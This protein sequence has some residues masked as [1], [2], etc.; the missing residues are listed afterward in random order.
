MNCFLLLIKRSNGCGTLNSYLKEELC[1]VRFD[2]ADWYSTTRLLPF[3]D[4]RLF[5]LSHLV[6]LGIAQI[7]SAKV[8]NAFLLVVRVTSHFFF[9]LLPKSRFLLASLLKASLY[10]ISA[11]LTYLYRMALAKFPRVWRHALFLYM[12]YGA[13]TD[14]EVDIC[15]Q[16]A[17]NILVCSSQPPL[18]YSQ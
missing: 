18:M 4:T 15:A 2:T 10:R 5:P 6:F 7:A 17:Q 3:L 1:F 14:L 13:F 9:L 16:A 11:V 12:C 8:E